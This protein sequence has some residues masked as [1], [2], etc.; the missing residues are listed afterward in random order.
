MVS[1]HRVGGPRDGTSHSSPLALGRRPSIPPEGSSCECRTADFAT[2]HAGCGHDRPRWRCG[3]RGA[4][5]SPLHSVCLA[6]AVPSESTRCL[7][8]TPPRKRGEGLGPTGDQTWMFPAFASCS[9]RLF[10]EPIHRE[11]SKG[12]R[13]EE[14]LCRG[15]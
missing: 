1:A 11:K 5:P 2:Q 8:L 6:E 13:G 7:S 15:Q 14:S 12:G 9:W 10:R 4:D 3:P